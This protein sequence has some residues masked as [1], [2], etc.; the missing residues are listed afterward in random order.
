MFWNIFA[1]ENTKTMKRAM[2]WV[3]L[4]L[5]VLFIILIFLVI[6]IVTKFNLGGEADTISARSMLEKMMTWPEALKTTLS[7]V[8]GNSLG[9][10][11]LVILVGAVTAQEYTWRTLHLWLSHGIPRPA[12]IGAKF[13]SLLLPAVIIVL[14]ALFA[15]GLI[16]AL[17]SFQIYGRL[18]V[19]EVNFI[20]LGLSALRTAYTLLPYASLTFLLAIACRSVV[21]AIGGA[22]AYTLLIEGFVVQILAALGGSFARLMQ[23][24]PSGLS[25]SLLML[26]TRI[27]NAASTTTAANMPIPMLDPIPAAI[28]IAVWTLLFTGLALWIFQRQ[29]L[30]E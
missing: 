25:N 15:G 6:F 21:A 22:L 27:S 16:S 20:Q 23:Y 1:N 7:L 4:S 17:I 30:S 26:N 9:G 13:L 3:E 19:D 24:L 12:L 29:D 14:S 5:L 11:L 10:L 8:S 2:F 28:G 18:P